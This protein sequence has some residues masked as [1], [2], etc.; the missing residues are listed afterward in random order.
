MMKRFF[1]AASAALALGLA[2]PDPSA[3]QTRPLVWG[4]QLPD[5]LDPHAVFDV[6][7]QYVLLNVYDGLYRYQGNPPELVPWLAEKH[8]VS[9]DGLTWTFSL[10]PGIKFHD[11]R[12]MTADDVVYSFQRVLG[13]GK[14]PSGAFKPVLKAANV[15]ALD[16]RT[17]QF[18]LDKPY[19]P[20]LAAVPI[21][22]IVNSEL[23]KKN[24]KDNDWGAGWL[25]ANAAGSGAYSMNPATY[26]PQQALDLTRF[27]EHFMGWGHNPK[28][29]DDVRSRM[30]LETSTRVLA[31]LRG[32]IDATDSYLPTD[33]VERVEKSKVAHVEQDE[34]MRVFVIRIN[35]KKP[36]L[37]NVHARKCLSYAFNYAGFIKEIMKDYAQRNPGPMPRNLWGA[38]KDAQGY[39]F[40]LEKAKQECDLARKAG[41][42]MDREIELHIQAALEQTTQAAQ[43]F[44]SDLKKIGLNVKIT[45]NTWPNLTASTGKPETT[46]DM[47]I[48]WVSTYFVDPENWV[49]QMY[50]SQFHGTWKASSWYQNPKVDEMLREARASTDK[51]KREKLYQ[52]A[53]K[54][55]MDEAADIW[56]YNTVQLRGLNNRVKGYTFSP[57]GGG[58][59]L[60]TMHLTQ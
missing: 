27:K 24:A 10:R 53:T 45:P 9:D 42:P 8:T 15:K 35:N 11:G 12:E 51:A 37:D 32:E 38:P 43:L 20:F 41:A 18:V 49:G 34:S 57:I 17:V 29:I 30:V 23:L 40:N 59:A 39:D 36:P 28:P 21:V 47:W 19:A 52:E 14:G 1:L 50:D 48:H 26:R 16:P 7:M 31:L 58:S 54:I 55:V 46:P 5:S 56:V 33:Q 6:P 13:I 2:A 4:D 25:A 22:A 60:R 44:Q 3:A